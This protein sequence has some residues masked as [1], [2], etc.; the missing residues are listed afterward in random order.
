MNDLNSR[1]RDTV[2]ITVLEQAYMFGTGY[3]PTSQPSQPSY[4]AGCPAQGSIFGG[5]TG[6]R[7]SANLE[8]T[9]SKGNLREFV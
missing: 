3:D 8:S 9:F 4:S 1:H 6:V 2:A 7:G 5:V